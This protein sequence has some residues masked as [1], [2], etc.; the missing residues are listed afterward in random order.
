MKKLLTVLFVLLLVLCGCNKE[1]NKESGT[2]ANATW[3]YTEY[4]TIEEMNKAVGTNITTAT[5]DGVKDEM[6]GVISKTL[7][8]Y[9]FVAGEEEW[10]IRASKDTEN[11]ISGIY[12]DAI[13]FEKDVTAVFYTDDYYVYRFFNNDTQYVISLNVKDKDIKTTYFDKVCGE[14]QT[15]ITG[16][17]SGYDNELVEEG[18][19][20]VYR[21]VMYGDDGTATTMETIYG[22]E[23]DKMVSI[24]NNMIFETDKAAKDYYDLLI[25]SGY[26]EDAL[27]LN[28]NIIT[29]SMDGN[30]DF[31]SD[32]TKQA[33]ID[34]M[35]SSLGME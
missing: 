12:H 8:Q 2:I 11:D 27:T 21:I 18:N 19:D 32:T 30:L 10:C 28:E 17:K 15:N 9:K 24:I 35:R 34:Q 23:N 26:D 25:E 29:S 4:K 1:E 13:T 14:F 16:I 22:F 5:M 20:V 7:A 31:Y 33:F 3:D 6:F